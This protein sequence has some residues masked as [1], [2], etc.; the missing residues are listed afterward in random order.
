MHHLL[1]GDVSIV[2]RLKDFTLLFNI[3]LFC[4]LV[5]VVV[6]ASAILYIT[7]RAHH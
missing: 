3:S 6:V 5:V 2:H 1:T 7:Q 4:C